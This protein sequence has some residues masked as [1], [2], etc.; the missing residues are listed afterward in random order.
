MQN[1]IES[2]LSKAD[3][4]TFKKLNKQLDTIESKMHKV[5]DLYLDEQID[6][7]TLHKKNNVLLQEK[8]IVNNQL[9]ELKQISK[10]NFDI[11]EIINFLIDI[12]E[13]IVQM[14]DK[15]KTC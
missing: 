9:E 8:A 10:I 15:I 7:E 14:D 4:N 3:K 13:K 11:D 2:I 1:Y 5:V 12:K 6:L